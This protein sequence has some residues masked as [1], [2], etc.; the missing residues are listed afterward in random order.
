LI[1][2]KTSNQIVFGYVLQINAYKEAWEE[3]TGNKISSAY[4]LRVGKKDKKFEIAPIP[5]NKKL[6]TTFLGVKN[7]VEQR[8][9]S[10]YI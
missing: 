10:K 4:C 2:L 9:I 1:D 5:L 8:E 6:F 7:I 3:E